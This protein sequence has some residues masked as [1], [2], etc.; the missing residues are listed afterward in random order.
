MFLLTLIENTKKSIYLRTK[1]SAGLSAEEEQEYRAVTV[2][3]K[4]DKS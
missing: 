4:T 2:S 1:H 3:V